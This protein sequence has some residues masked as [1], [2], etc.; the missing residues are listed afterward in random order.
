MIRDQWQWPQN[1]SQKGLFFFPGRKATCAVPFRFVIRRHALF[2][3]FFYSI[4]III[5]FFFSYFSIIFFSA[6]DYD[7]RVQAIPRFQWTISVSDDVSVFQSTRDV[8]PCRCVLFTARQSRVDSCGGIHVYI[9]IMYIYIY[10]GVIFCLT[11]WCDEA[12]H[13]II[14]LSVFSFNMHLIRDDSQNGTE[15]SAYIIRIFTNFSM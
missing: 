15:P 12:K 3:F 11:G 9:N 7:S 6:Y 14:D 13:L 8:I 1:G 5:T 10:K 2:F 4:Y